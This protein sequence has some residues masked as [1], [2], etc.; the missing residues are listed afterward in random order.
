MSAEAKYE[1]LSPYQRAA[2]AQID[3]LTRKSGK[4][5]FTEDDVPFRCQT[6][7]VLQAVGLLSEVG[8][9]QGNRKRA[10][11][12]S[13][14]RKPEMRALMRL[15]AGAESMSKAKVRGKTK[16]KSKARPKAKVAA[17]RKTKAK[18][19]KK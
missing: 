8:L 2:V 16:T 14:N 13:V 12:F 18:A 4:P 9:V 11:V 6:W 10:R 7:G 17:K 5:T 1:E 15:C 3:E 19:R